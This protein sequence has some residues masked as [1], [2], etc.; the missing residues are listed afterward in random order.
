MANPILPLI[1]AVDLTIN[2]GEDWCAAV[3]AAAPGDTVTL[4]GG[5][6]AGPCW[7][8]ASGEDGSPITLAGDG[9]SVVYSG[10]SSNVIDIAG[11]HLVL[12]GLS[13]GPTNADID[14]IK[15]RSG[16]DLEIRANAFTRVGGISVSA[17]SADTAGVAI[18]DNTFEDLQATGVYLGCHDGSCVSAGFTIQGNRWDG[19]TSAAVGYAM[20]TKLGSYGTI[21]DNTVNDA[22]G[23][24]VEVYGSTGG[25]PTVVERN[26]LI[27]SRAAATLEIGGGPAIVRNNVVIGGDAGGLY[28]YDYGGRG[29]VQD[30]AVQG[31]TLW[32]VGGAAAELSGW[33]SG[34][35]LSFEDNAVGRDD[36]GAALPAVID[37]VP[38]EGNVDC[39]DGAACWRDAAG[40]DLW[41]LAGGALVGAGVV[42]DPPLVED[43]CGRGRS[44]PPTVGALEP[45]SGE[46]GSFSATATAATLCVGEDTGTPDS[47]EAGDDSGEAGDDSGEASDDSGGG[48]AQPTDKGGCACASSGARSSAPRL[49]ALAALATLWRR[50]RPHATLHP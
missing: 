31:N 3:N 5:E 45:G 34:V 42:T 29:M 43:W 48:S 19:V 7:I 26:L 27:G 8:T 33:T 38:M 47:G 44:E 14:A 17:N 37:G 4:V 1:L 39:G 15:I 10:S 11:S 40:W 13:F 46:E 18:L 28:V 23:P 50:R 2:P 20:E 12:T 41:P 25:E 49:L 21:A 22:Q 30:I 16:E 36:G 32:G 9:A 6:H 35:G 24:A